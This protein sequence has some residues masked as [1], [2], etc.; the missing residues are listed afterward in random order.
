MITTHQDTF[1]EEF[2]AGDH[3]TLF[4]GTADISAR[5]NNFRKKIAHT[6]KGF[7]TEISALK[8]VLKKCNSDQKH[9]RMLREWLFS[10]TSVLESRSAR[11]Q[12]YNIKLLTLVNIVFL[13]LMFVTSVFGMTNMP[14]QEGF[15][16]FGGVIV[17]V[18]VPTF[19]LILLISYHEKLVPVRKLL[20]A[21][22]DKL[23]RRKTKAISG[24]KSHRTRDRKRLK[25][26][27]PNARHSSLQRRLTSLSENEAV[28]RPT[29]LSDQEMTDLPKQANAVDGSPVPRRPT[30]KWSEPFDHLSQK[31]ASNVAEPSPNTSDVEVKSPIK[32][33]DRV[34]S[35]EEAPSKRDGGPRRQS[36][37]R[38]FSSGSGS[39]RPAQSPV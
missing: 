36:L 13:P 24:T 23:L 26:G 14:Q 11:K 29:G 8:E 5:Y 30:I 38:R 4:V 21:Q 32:R 28:R 12:D 22:Y 35:T 27:Q 25:P 15:V 3:K 6:H 1:T 33:P 18:A 2:W 17:A 37:L 7:E 34:K 10:G 9:I 31:H 20:W 19:A 16:R 39:E